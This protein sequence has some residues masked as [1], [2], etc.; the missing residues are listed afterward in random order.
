MR[1]ALGLPSQ[2]VRQWHQPL[3]VPAPVH[4]L[5]LGPFSRQKQA[6][7]LLVQQ[8]ALLSKHHWHKASLWVTLSR[9]TPREEKGPPLDTMGHPAAHAQGLQE[10]PGRR[11]QEDQ[12]GWHA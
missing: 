1:D 4:E 7:W 9:E 6:A 11:L 10:R 5:Q 8:R 3:A 2:A 12:M